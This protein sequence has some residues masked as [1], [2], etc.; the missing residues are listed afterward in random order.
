MIQHEEEI[1]NEQVAHSQRVIAEVE[2]PGL[3]VAEIA[4][5]PKGSRPLSLRDVQIALVA[6]RSARSAGRRASF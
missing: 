3:S 2:D 1:L 6:R 5:L 4:Q